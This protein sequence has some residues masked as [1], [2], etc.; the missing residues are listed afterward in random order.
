[1][2]DVSAMTN[3]QEWESW[4]IIKIMC[5]SYQ[6]YM[7]YITVSARSSWHVKI[8]NTVTISIS[9]MELLI[10]N[11][12][13]DGKWHVMLNWGGDLWITR[14]V[15]SSTTRCTDSIAL[16]SI[17]ANIHYV[18]ESIYIITYPDTVHID[19]YLHTPIRIFVD[20]NI[21]SIILQFYN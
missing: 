1:M 6:L 17:M 10:G 7:G 13:F 4:P 3:S 5:I 11:P 8:S 19:S 21:P 2:G 12:Y 15:R 9:Y 16:S 18:Y 20:E 14:M